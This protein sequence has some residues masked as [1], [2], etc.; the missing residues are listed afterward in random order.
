MLLF[1]Q[2][3]QTMMIIIML[4]FL[5]FFYVRTH[6]NIEFSILR[7]STIHIVNDFYI[8]NPFLYIY[9]N[10]Y[11]K[12]KVFFC[13]KCIKLLIFPYTGFFNSVKEFLIC[14]CYQKHMPIT[15]ANNIMPITYANNICQF[16]F[17]IKN[18][19]LILHCILISFQFHTVLL[20]NL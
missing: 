4:F 15:Y 8:R 11:E 14:L 12:N 7:N 10:C 17:L 16:N 1:L 2:F 9:K 3:C 20:L 18:F 5:Q 19:F 13:I 6:K